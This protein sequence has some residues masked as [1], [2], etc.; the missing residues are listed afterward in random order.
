MSLLHERNYRKEGY[1]RLL[2][3]RIGGG[4]MT[5]TPRPHTDC[6]SEIRECRTNQR[7]SEIDAQPSLFKPKPQQ[8]TMENL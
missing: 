7:L 5:Y 4:P 3:A 8:L 2:Q 1:L 6:L